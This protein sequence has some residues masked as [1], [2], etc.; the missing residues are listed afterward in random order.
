MK[1]LFSVLIALAIS[2]SAFSQSTKWEYCEV[3]S[4]MGASLTK[5]S[6]VEVTFGD[7]EKS[8][9]S[10]TNVLKDEAGNTIKFKTHVEALNYLGAQGWESVLAYVEEQPGNMFQV[11][12]L[13]R[14]KYE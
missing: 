9:G 4:Y 3:I 6:S 13:L 1:S 7:T 5:K 11:H 8:W 14:R 12:I 10:K 2:G